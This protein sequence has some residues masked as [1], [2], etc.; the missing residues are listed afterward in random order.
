MGAPTVV[1]FMEN[2]RSRQLIQMS[3]RYGARCLW[4]TGS[5][6]RFH[7]TFNSETCDGL[8]KPAGTGSCSV[9]YSF[10]LICLMCDISVFV[11]GSLICL[12]CDISV[13]VA[14][15]LICL[16]CDISVFV[17][18]SLI[19][20]MC[21]ISVFVAGSLCTYVTYSICSVM[22]RSRCESVELFCS[23]G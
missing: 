23:S 22:A 1:A 16:M 9:H 14:G 8:Y 15:S 10:S 21:D 7:N 6:I 12:M 5:D 13:F 19:C 11:A 4:Q 20:L 3:V 17:A 18:G 2:L